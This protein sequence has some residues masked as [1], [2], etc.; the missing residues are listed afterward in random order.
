M[1][2]YHNYAKRYR[3][4]TPEIRAASKNHWLE[5]YREKFERGECDDDVAMLAA[6]VLA[7]IAVLEEE[8]GENGSEEASA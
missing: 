3:A 1:D 7:L 4:A 6:R 8:A 5:I 2:W